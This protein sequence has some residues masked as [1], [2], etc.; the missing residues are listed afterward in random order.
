MQTYISL[1]NFTD[2]GIK[3]VKGTVERAQA[4]KKA[5]E[6][7]GGRVIGVWW[8]IGQYDLVLIAEMQSDEAMARL[9]MQTGM[10]GNVRT[11]SMRAFSEE[12]ESRIVKGLP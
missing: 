11:M 5:A 9:L 3:N 2:Q 4:V 12:E 7:A 8:T 1:T 10:L 6:A